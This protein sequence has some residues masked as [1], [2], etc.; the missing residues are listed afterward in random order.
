MDHNEVLERGLIEA[1]HRGEIPPEEE[2]AFEAHFFACPACTEQLEMA[3]GFQRG[4]KAMV[5]EDLARQA[6]QVGLFAWL[7]RRSVLAR[8]GAVLAALLL[9]AGLPL[10]WLVS[11]RSELRTAREERAALQSRASALE[12]QVA[13]QEKQ[14][15]EARRRLEEQ[16]AALRAEQ[17]SG[18]TPAE[19]PSAEG[20]LVNTPV[21]LLALVRGTEKEGGTSIDPVKAGSHFSLALDVEEAPGVA[22]YRITVSDARGKERFR[23]DG[24]RRNSLET[25]LVTFPSSYFPPGG[26]RLKVEGLDRQGGSSAVGEYRFRIARR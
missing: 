22:T 1:Y 8:W 16:L 20:P 7:A 12:A 6:M 17:G 9:V 18:N 26:Y 24:I 14:G 11:E 2:A 21:F 19:R 3:R 13:A 5:A 25:L 10:L 23:R 15:S 4:L